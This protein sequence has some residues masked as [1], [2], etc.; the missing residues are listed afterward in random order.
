[1]LSKIFHL[2]I[3]LQSELKLIEEQQPP[4]LSLLFLPSTSGTKEKKDNDR[5]SLDMKAIGWGL[6]DAPCPGA[7]HVQHGALTDL[8]RKACLIPL[9]VVNPSGRDNT[10][11]ST[12]LI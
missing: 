11:F 4:S 6:R 12:F 5:S 8:C 1:M 9:S 7:P 10:G 2:I 3:T